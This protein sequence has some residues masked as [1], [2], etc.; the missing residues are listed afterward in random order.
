MK[1]KLKAL[2]ILPLTILFVFSIIFLFIFPFSVANSAIGGGGVFSLTDGAVN[3]NAGDTCVEKIGDT[4]HVSYN[5]QSTMLLISGD[6]V[7]SVKNTS[8]FVPKILENVK[9]TLVSVPD[10][11]KYKEIRAKS[12]AI[13][14]G[15]ALPPVPARAVNK[16]LE[17]IDA[18][19]GAD[20]NFFDGKGNEAPFENGG[21][22][23]SDLNDANLG[24]YRSASYVDNSAPENMR[25]VKYLNYKGT[26]GELENHE[27]YNEYTF[28]INEPG[29]FTI[30]LEGD[31]KVK[32][33]ITVLPIRVTNTTRR[34]INENAG[35]GSYDEFC[36][37]LT[38]YSQWQRGSLPKYS[39][40]DL[41]LNKDL[42]AKNTKDGL[43]TSS[44]C[45]VTREIG[46]NSL[47]GPDI[48]ANNN[49]VYDTYIRMFTLYANPATSYTLNGVNEDGCDQSAVVVTL[50][51]QKP[52]VVP[53][54]VNVPQKP[55]VV[56]PA[57]NVPQKPKRFAPNSYPNL[58]ETGFSN[59]V[60]VLIGIFS[61]IAFGILTYRKVYNR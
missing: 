25:E 7:Q 13:S 37:E 57:V 29:V 55:P 19:A 30:K 38:E 20:G 39:L 53:P 10:L 18:T 6:S 40:T 17:I 8:V 33:E 27:M 56:P 15:T 34:C 24:V 35:S 41:A 45:V 16:S 2:Y 52:P 59:S 46:S 60:I 48:V 32:S 11:E 31:V 28:K 49:S 12:P 44:Q 58:A 3:C 21:L 22:I 54:A 42:L 61:I 14:T 23:S 26:V 43:A 50:C 47:I 36:Q 4:A 51:P 9:L 5:I 1:T